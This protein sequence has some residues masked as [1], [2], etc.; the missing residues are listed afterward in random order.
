MKIHEGVWLPMKFHEGG[1]WPMKVHEGGWWLWME[2]NEWWLWLSYI[3]CLASNLVTQS[4]V[5]EILCRPFCQSI[6]TS[7][8]RPNSFSSLFMDLFSI[9]AFRTVLH[10]KIQTSIYIFG[11]II[12]RVLPEIT[13]FNVDTPKFL[14]NSNPSWNSMLPARQTWAN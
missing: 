5:L 12:G 3:F 2:F 11:S 14:Q 8:L 10:Y 13:Y 1:W 7:L 4:S 6:L 9:P